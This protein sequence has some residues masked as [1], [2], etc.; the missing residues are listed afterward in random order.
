MAQ[1]TR[2]QILTPLTIGLPK[3]AVAADTTSTASSPR[4]TAVGG[5]S[6]SSSESGPMSSSYEGM[7]GGRTS[8]GLG[9]SPFGLPQGDQNAAS[10][11]AHCY[12]QLMKDT[13]SM[14]SGLAALETAID[15]PTIYVFIF[16][17]PRSGNQ[18]G[19]GLM[20]MALRN[21]RLRER[22]SVQVQIYDVTDEAS[23][24]E[25]LHYLHQLQLRQ[26]DRL[27][28]TAFPE[29]FVQ[30]AQAGACGVRPSPPASTGRA[31][32]GGG[33]AWEEWISDAAAH[34][35]CGLAQLGDAEVVARLE[36]AQESAVKLHV[37][38]AGGDGTVSATLQVLM[39]HGI[40]VGRVYFSCI[41]FG[42]GN[43][44]ADALGWGRS[45]A[46]DALGDGMHGLSR[47][48]TERLDG[49]T[50]KLDIYEITVTTY[51][52]GYVK[53]VE[54]NNQ[55]APGARRH[56]RLMIDYLSLGVQGF[57]GASFEMHRP[58]RRAL[59]ILM[60]TAAAAHWVLARAFPP[61]TEALESVATVPAAMLAD[62]ALTDAERARWLE[63][64]PEAERRRVLLAS[65]AAPGSADAGL[66][67]I[68]G[69]PIE[70][71]VQNVARFWGRNIDV[72][73][74]ARGAGSGEWTPQYAGD[75]KVELF[76]VQSMADYTL[77]QLPHRDTYRVDRQAQ[78]P[79]PVA[80]HFR[81]PAEYPVRRRR[82]RLLPWRRAPPPGLLNAMCDGEFVE[83]FRPRDVIVAR[84]VTLK[85]VGRSPE[86]SRIVLDT[87]KNDGLDAV[88]MDPTAAARGRL[89]D[90]PAVA[91]YVAA[92]FQ[93]IFRRAPPPPPS[94]ARD[95]TLASAEPASAQPPPPPL[96]AATSSRS[97]LLSFR[98]SLLRTV[99]HRRSAA[100]RD[101][102]SLSD[103]RLESVATLPVA[104]SA[105][106]THRVHSKSIDLGRINP[107]I[108]ATA[109]AGPAN[110]PA[111]NSDTL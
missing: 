95:N 31:A 45:V 32:D 77:N 55:A 12:E 15:E 67:V 85:A 42:T 34:L 64:A 38:S 92:P 5:T 4:H 39:D 93:R 35:E 41:P 19:R 11:L 61:I 21:F 108:S 14:H 2:Q 52:G 76:T 106:L 13:S 65:R 70:L 111:N 99:R 86:A 71:D 91:S 87:I 37:W 107:T 100:S 59:N 46:G 110:L 72:W 26:G 7:A 83:I 1:T 27:L 101:A 68:G 56:T 10:F 6:S 57:V 50:C 49:Y 17:N 47:L 54:K 78:M 62:A 89:A 84:K 40:D 20:R 82:A 75:G 30:Q 97:A 81:P 33:A 103:I 90:P 8:S 66:P 73:G 58:G 109:A 63:D 98:E 29:L 36:R 48:V 9:R 94:L 51:D 69:R 22:P 79:A 53:H 44:F 102:P 24:S 88:H 104:P 28:R 74:R 23:R 16:T 43:D 25:G 3:G 105:V 80:L 60:Y 96:A 18:Q